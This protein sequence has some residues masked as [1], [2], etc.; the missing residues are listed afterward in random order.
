MQLQTVIRRAIEIG[1]RRGFITFDQLNEFCPDDI[2]PEQIE[3]LF[4]ALS[5]EGINVMDEPS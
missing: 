3:A 4:E 5:E 2:E 1:L